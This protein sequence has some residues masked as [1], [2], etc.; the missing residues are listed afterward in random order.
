MRAVIVVLHI[1]LQYKLV[2]TNGTSGKCYSMRSKPVS[3][4]GWGHEAVSHLNREDSTTR[5]SREKKAEAKK[6][7]EQTIMTKMGVAMKE[8]RITKKI[9]N[10]KSQLKKKIN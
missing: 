5:C 6:I 10:M 1:H 9:A 7:A 8:K 4:F 2:N 3:G